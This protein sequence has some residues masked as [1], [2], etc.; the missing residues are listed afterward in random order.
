MNLPTIIVAAVIGVLFVVIVACEIR[1]RKNG[2]GG[3]S[4]GGSC[5]GCA[6]SGMCHSAEDST[7]N[8]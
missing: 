2:K 6:M 4:C 8:Q 5:G 1:K 3:C 7:N